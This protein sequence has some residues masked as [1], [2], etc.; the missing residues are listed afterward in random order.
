MYGRQFSQNRNSRRTKKMSTNEGAA[1][2]SRGKDGC[3]N[4][5]NVRLTAQVGATTSVTGGR[6]RF[7]NHT[8]SSLLKRKEP[9][10]P[11]RRLS[12]T[13]VVA[14]VLQ[15]SRRN[16]APLSRLSGVSKKCRATKQS[17]SMHALKTIIKREK[18]RQSF[19]SLRGDSEQM[20]SRRGRR[21][22][23][24]LVFLQHDLIN[25]VSCDFKKHM[26]SSSG[27]IF[28]QDETPEFVDRLEEGTEDMRASRHGDRTRY[29]SHDTQRCIASP[30]RNGRNFSKDRSIAEI[31]HELQQTND[32]DD[33]NTRCEVEVLH[34]G[35]KH[36]GS[37][38]R[39]QSVSSYEYRPVETQIR[40]QVRSTDLHSMMIHKRTRT[41]QKIWMNR[42]ATGRSEEVV[43]VDRINSR[44]N[45]KFMKHADR[46]RGK[47][48]RSLMNSK[49]VSCQKNHGLQKK[50]HSSV[51]RVG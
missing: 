1:T 10:R 30:S 33:K 21:I 7:H 36:R 48:T 12:S 51:E 46:T 28:L 14:D 11:R 2:K 49:T 15:K 45:V 8:Q 9:V 47:D 17:K 41:E 22:G 37:G 23:N 31:S 6:P 42:K 3:V 20:T 43:D 32:D 34:R 26:G 4:P 27:L 39:P 13:S 5:M 38:N 19:D 25:N 29:V 40:E 18:D 50:E 44:G 16:V 35:A 24:S